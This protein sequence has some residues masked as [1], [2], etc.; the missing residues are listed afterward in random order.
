VGD[1]QHHKP[2][3][4]WT[5]LPP[6]A[7]ATAFDIDAAEDWLEAAGSDAPGIMADVLRDLGWTCRPPHE[8]ATEGL[9]TAEK[10]EKG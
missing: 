1:E 3:E 10:A 7:E 4:Q 6:P 5:S 8:D 2:A 9:T